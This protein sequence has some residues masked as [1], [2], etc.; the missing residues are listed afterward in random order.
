MKKKGQKGEGGGSR[1][2]LIAC[3]CVFVAA[4]VRERAEGAGDESRFEDEDEDEES[5]LWPAGMHAATTKR[6][7]G[8]VG[9]RG[10]KGPF[11]SR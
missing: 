10:G 6:R 3:A 1:A 8:G 11:S 4:G 7:R 9:G 5:P 2:G